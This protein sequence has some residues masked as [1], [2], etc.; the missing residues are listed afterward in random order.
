VNFEELLGGDDLTP[1]EEAK[2]RRV[3]EL[4]IEAGPPPDLPPAL[5][6]PAAPRDAD[7]IE[8]PFI[9]RRRNAALAIVAVAAALIALAGGY[10]W[11]HSKSPGPSFTA[12][13]TVPMH[14]S[15]GRLAVITV[16]A[17]DKAGNWPML[18]SVSGLP[19]Q[20]NPRAYYELWLT[21]DGKPVAPCGGFRVHS[22]TTSV[23]LS[24][25]YRLSRYDGWVVT[26][27][28]PTPAAERGP[29][30]VVLTT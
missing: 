12:V 6:H 16:G 5:E 3:H 7:V 10:A 25:P 1:E 24:V 27:Q 18:V 14:G 29:G 23:T 20:S 30:P 8:Y 19:T 21:R 13:R 9:A 11:G 22:T 15:A 28:V 2:L 26:A 17:P 4:L